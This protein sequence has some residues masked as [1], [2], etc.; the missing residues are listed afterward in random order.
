M[1]SEAFTVLL[2]QDLEMMKEAESDVETERL[3]VHELTLKIE[4]M[5]GKERE[6]EMLDNLEL[7]ELVEKGNERKE[8]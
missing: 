2:L 8:T 7:K 6:K 4:E 1:H 3:G 5:E